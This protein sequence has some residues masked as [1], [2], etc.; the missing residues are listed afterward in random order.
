MSEPTRVFKY[1]QD[2]SA[3]PRGSGNMKGIADYCMDFAK[4]HA[5]RAVRD[6]ADNV[7]I[8]KNGTAGYENTP[9]VILQGHLDMV[10]QKDPSCNIDLSKD[11]LDLYTEGDFLKARGTTLGADNG[12]AV[13]MTLAILESDTIPHPPIEAVF[14][15]DEEVGMLGAAVLDTSILKAKKMINLDSEE[16]D[17]VTVSCAGGSDLRIT[18]PLTRKRVSAYEFS[19]ILSGLRGGHSGIEIDK[20]RVNANTLAGRFLNHMQNVCAFDII[21]I[22]GGDKSNAIPNRCEMRLSVT[23]EHAFKAEASL[24]LSSIKKELSDREPGFDFCIKGHGVTEHEKTDVTDSLVYALCCAQ[25]G[26]IEMSAE[27]DGLVESSQNLGILITERNEII[28][29][30][31]LRSNKKTA[32]KYLEERL[33]TFAK[34]FENA[35]VKTFG[36]YPP[37][38]FKSDSSLQKKYFQLF[39]SKFGYKPKV[40]AIHAGLECGIFSD[41]IKG[42]DCIS[43]GPELYDVH[44]VNERLSISSTQK[45]YE[46]LLDI[47]KTE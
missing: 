33:C 26:V 14:T 21:S 16:F 29:H 3:I 43:I 20:G 2:I 42:L 36:H 27:I 7:I 1:F 30:F 23:D 6:S 15:T 40:Q 31:S 18:V 4:D 8:F 46:L 25:S 19:V 34:C 13:A 45:L 41:K 24:F 10:C 35:Q 44:T 9:P 17:Y 47:L 38:E 39:E 5:L 11:G 28:I 12:S 22:N 37:W 32:L